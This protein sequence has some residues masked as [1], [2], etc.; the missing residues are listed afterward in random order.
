MTRQNASWPPDAAFAINDKALGRSIRMSH[1]SECD[2]PAMLK[3]MRFTDASTPQGSALK[4]AQ[5]PSP[6][7]YCQAIRLR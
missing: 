5:Y 1:Q 4:F 7:R 3:P 2:K 6:Q